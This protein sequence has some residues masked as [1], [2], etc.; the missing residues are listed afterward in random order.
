[1][2]GLL[3]VQHG[4]ASG[5]DVLAAGFEVVPGGATFETSTGVTAGRPLGQAPM[6]EIVQ[7]FL[8]GRRDSGR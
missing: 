2:T 7:F 1:M 8:V 6:E 3:F 4:L 5:C